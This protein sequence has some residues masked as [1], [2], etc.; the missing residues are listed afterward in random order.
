M[1]TV[2]KQNGIDNEALMSFR[3]PLAPPGAQLGESGSSQVAGKDVI[4][5]LLSFL[6]FLFMKNVKF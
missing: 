5:I 4:A 2:I 6:I 1:E 3:N